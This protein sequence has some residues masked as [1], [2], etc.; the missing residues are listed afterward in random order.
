MSAQG[1]IFPGTDMPDAAW[2]EALWPDPGSVLSAVGLTGSMSAVDLC[3]GDGWFTL[4]MARIARRV[5][6]IDL[7]ERLLEAARARLAR[8]G[9]TNCDFVLGDAYDVARLV[10]PRADLVFLA[11][12][13]HGVPDGRRLADAV[14]DALAPGGRFAI[15]NWHQRPHEETIVLGVPR[16][17]ATAMRMSPDQVVATVASDRLSLERIVELAPYHYAAVF[18]RT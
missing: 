6:A 4:P 18:D 11:N 12:V 13:F 8:H 17:P 9:V 5:V 16:G 10:S 3:C 15:V 1:S 14:A 2:W 7:D